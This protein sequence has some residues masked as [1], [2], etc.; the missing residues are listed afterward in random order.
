MKQWNLSSI[1]LQ[2]RLALGRVGGVA[3]LTSAL[4]LTALA[5]WFWQIPQARLQLVADSADEKRLRSAL[6]SPAA[7]PVAPPVSDNQQRFKDF[8]DN[9]GERHYV[10]QQLK[11]LFAIA[12][13]NGLSLSQGDYSEVYDKRGKFYAYRVKLPVKGA[14]LPIR[15]FCEQVLLAIPFA[16]LDD[17]SFKRDGIAV[18]TLEARIGL[19]LYLADDDGG[20]SASETS[21]EAEQTEPAK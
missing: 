3:L 4:A 8:Q 13:K 10:E 9:L 5:I 14:Y 16:S 11:T 6:D 18:P 7:A 1:V 19:T 20:S 12:T 2:C 17:I 15:A 21:R